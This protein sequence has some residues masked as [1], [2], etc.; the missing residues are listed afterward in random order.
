MMM[1]ATGG[2]GVAGIS[3]IRQVI[4]LDG[5]QIVI[6]LIDNRLP[7]RNFEAGYLG[8]GNAGQVLDQRPLSQELGSAL[9]AANA[10]QSEQAPKSD[11]GVEDAEIVEEQ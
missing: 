10:A 3:A 1:M 6:E 8:I 5:I 2:A 4:A 9:Y 11:D 7:G